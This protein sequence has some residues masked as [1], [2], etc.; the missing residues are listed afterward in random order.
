MSNKSKPVWLDRRVARP[1]PYLMLCL[2]STELGKVSRKLLG[3]KLIFPLY[4]AVCH[5]FSRPD[6][7]DICA[8][9]SLSKQAQKKCTSLEITGL[10][11]HEAVHVWQAYLEDMGEISPGA[12]QEAYAIQAIA[13]ELLFEYERRTL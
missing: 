10:L 2:N 12:E 11:I 13:Q 8:I 9:I 6:T 1:A 7:S 3:A 5:T 4:G